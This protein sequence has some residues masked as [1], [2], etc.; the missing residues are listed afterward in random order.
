M[1]HWKVVLRFEKRQYTLSFWTGLAHD[2]PTTKDVM[3]C[4]V[5]DAHICLD[6]Q[7]DEWL[8]PESI[9]AIEEQTER[10]E[11]LMG[12]IPRPDELWKIL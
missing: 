11:T 6:D 9:K 7:E 10:L 2:R 8:S 3:A 5:S 1:N 12:Y 4:L